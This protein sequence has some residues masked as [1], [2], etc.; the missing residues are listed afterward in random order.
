MLDTIESLE[1]QAETI[2]RRRAK[3]LGIS[4][5]GQVDSRRAST[6]PV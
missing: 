2:V 6:D 4:I 5:E 1:A 3:A